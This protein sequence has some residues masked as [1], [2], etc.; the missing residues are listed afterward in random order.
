MIAQLIALFVKHRFNL[1]VVAILSMIVG[2]QLDKETEVDHLFSRYNEEFTPGASLMIIKDGNPLITKGYGM[3]HLGKEIPVT[4]ETT[5]RLASITKQ[6]TAAGIMLLEEEGHLEYFFTLTEIFPGFPEYGKEITIRHLL[7]HTSGLIDYEDLIPDTATVQVTDEDVLAMMAAQDSAYFAPGS[8][9]RYSNSGY[10]VLAM[11][12]EKYSGQ[13][14]P[15]FMKAYIFD[16]LGMHNTVAYVKGVNEV[17]NRS[18]G[19]TKTGD[20]TFEDSDQSITSA[21]LGDGGIYSSVNDMFLWD[22]ALYG[23]TI[24]SKES[25]IEATTPAV[26]ANGD[27]TNYGFGWR[28]DERNGYPRMHHAG[29]TSGFRNIY[30]R[31]PG[32]GF[33]V[34]VLTNRAEPDVT[35]IADAI[36]DLYLY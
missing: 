3:A 24:L 16:P 13:T 20:D 19:Y 27:T 23:E 10:A 22:Q 14:Y 34:I 32:E 36:S 5:F 28:V 2:F 8:E 31:Y 29:S 7:N 21:V 33:S 1:L 35:Y 15:A 25:L 6:F 26:L 17:P 4:P 18:Y 11:I 9:Y 30:Q 12:I